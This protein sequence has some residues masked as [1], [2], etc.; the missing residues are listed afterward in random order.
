MNYTNQWRDQWDSLIFHLWMK[1]ILYDYYYIT[2][3]YSRQNN[4]KWKKEEKWK[5]SN[6]Y[7]ESKE[8]QQV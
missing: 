5:K 7:L 1:K 2:C 3:V 6:Q 8:I 4:Y